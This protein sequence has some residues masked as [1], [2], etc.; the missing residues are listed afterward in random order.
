MGEY[1]CA[2]KVN[3]LRVLF[4]SHNCQM[5]IFLFE[6]CVMK[7]ILRVHNLDILSFRLALP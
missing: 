6:D 3:Y 2:P 4:R 5:K 7:E 1:V